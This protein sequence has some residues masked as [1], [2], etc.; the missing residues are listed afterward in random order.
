MLASLLDLLSIHDSGTFLVRSYLPRVIVNAEEVDRGMYIV[1]IT[2]ANVRPSL[3]K[4][5]R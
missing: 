5:C 4:P 1:E 2:I 3:A